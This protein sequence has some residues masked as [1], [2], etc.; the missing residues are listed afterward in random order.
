[1]KRFSR[2][3]VATFGFVVLGCVISLVPQKSATGNPDRVHV[4]DDGKTENVNVVNTPLPVKGTVNASQNGTWN[5]GITG[6]PSVNVG[7]PTVNLGAGST[8]GIN[9]SVQIGNTA[10]S[11]VLVRDVENPARHPIQ[12]ELC[13]GIGLPCD[14]SLRDEVKVPS[15]EEVVIEYVSGVCSAPASTTV[16]LNL[17]TTAGGVPEFHYFNEITVGPSGSTQFGQLTRIY[18]DPSSFIRSDIHGTH[19][20]IL[21]IVTLSG[22]TVTL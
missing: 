20:P 17:F 3:L 14:P 10:T 6:N 2:A 11:P 16:F 9:G 12:I 8:V 4:H 18:A 5:V 22:H 1:M 13:N 21:C 7:T 15:G 19:E